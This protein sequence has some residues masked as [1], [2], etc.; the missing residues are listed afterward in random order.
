M[1]PR[2]RNV[3]HLGDYRLELEFNDGTVGEL[4]FRSQVVGRGGVFQP[5]TT[6]SFFQQVQVDPE[7]G[8]IV[9]PNG[10][11]LCPDTLY[12]RLTQKLTDGA[13]TSLASSIV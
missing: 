1:M 10:V 2:V 5:L 12:Q 13:T 4:D 7:A 8:T 11:D 3:R 6:I 9:W